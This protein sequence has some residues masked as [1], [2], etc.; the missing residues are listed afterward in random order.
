VRPYV[1]DTVPAYTGTF[2]IQG[3][4]AHPEVQCPTFWTLANRGNLMVR[5]GGRMLFAQTKATGALNYYVSFRQPADWLARQGITASNHAALSQLL[6]SEFATWAALFRDAFRATQE[7]ALLPMYRLPLAGFQARSVT[8][9]VTLIG[10]AAHV[11]PPFAGVGV[12]IGLLDAL[13]LADNLTSGQFSSLEAAIAAYERAMYAYAHEAQE[14]TAEAEL[15]I[16]S[17]KSDAELLAERAAW[18]EII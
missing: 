10:D 2:I 13:T 14:G 8:H 15:N 18:N 17:T 3:E 11:M 9:P 4:I 7:F 12:N 6:V 16:H 1:L 5:A